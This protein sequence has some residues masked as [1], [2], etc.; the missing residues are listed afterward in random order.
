MGRSGKIAVAAVAIGLLL[1]IAVASALRKPRP[2]TD[3]ISFPAPEELVAE[4]ELSR[5]RTLT[6]PDAG[7]EAAWEEKRRRFFGKG[8]AR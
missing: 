4:P 6:M 7:C 1:T 2:A 8:E 3:V 5:C